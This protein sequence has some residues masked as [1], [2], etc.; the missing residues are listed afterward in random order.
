MIKVNQRDRLALKL[1][2]ILDAIATLTF[3]LGD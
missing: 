2:G 1:H 3:K